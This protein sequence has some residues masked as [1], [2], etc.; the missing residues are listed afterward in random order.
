MPARPPRA[1]RTVLAARAADSQAADSRVPPTVSRLT[2]EFRARLD[3]AS[4]AAAVHGVRLQVTSG[5]RS[6]QQQEGL[7]RLYTKRYGSR[8]AAYRWA[9]PV[10]QS[11][12]VRGEAVDLGAGAAWLRA[13]GAVFGLC[14]RYRSEPWH[15]EM[16]IEPGGS[17]PALQD[18][19]VA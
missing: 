8:A 3:R 9:L 13:H 17:C 4:R 7:I 18:H 15:F 12:H 11:L 19:P 6:P 2:P 14:R 1:G 5:W 16:L 10:D